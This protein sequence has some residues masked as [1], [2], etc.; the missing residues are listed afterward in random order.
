MAKLKKTLP[1]EFIDYCSRHCN[2]WSAEDIEKCKEM[3][4]ACEPDARERGTYNE[5]ALHK[6]IPIELPEWL[7]ERGADVNAEQTYG[8]PI[9]KH[10]RVGHYDICELMIKHGANLNALDY[11]EK[12]PLFAAADGGHADIVKMFLENGADPNHHEKHFGNNIGRTPLLNMLERMRPG[13]RGNAATARILLEAQGGKDNI[14]AK[15]W[16]MAQGFV[17]DKGK[18]FE[19]HKSDME[20]EYRNNAEAEM[21]EFYALFEVDAPAPIVKHDGVTKIEIDS[22]LSFSEQ[23][24]KLWEY[25]VP[26]SGKCDTL[27]GE[28]IRITGCVGDEVYRNGGANWDN[29]YLKMIHA[30]LE[31]LTQGQTAIRDRF[32][33]C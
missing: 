30:L 3:L 12:T 16:E 24:K 33:R 14:P 23:Y 19:F 32:K 15:E 1:K 28:V 10:A 25:L 18:D 6:Y 26:A 27:Q 11:M 13:D 2:N 4:T 9:F 8:T 21:L 17:S 20:E 5:T 7:I 22:S 29:E 31:F